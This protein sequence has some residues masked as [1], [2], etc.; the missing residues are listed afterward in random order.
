M[1]MAVCMSCDGECNVVLML[2]YTVDDSGV[3]CV[4]MVIGLV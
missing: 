2:F 3:C 1:C 4:G